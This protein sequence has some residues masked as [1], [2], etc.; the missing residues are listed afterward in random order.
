[1]AKKIIEALTTLSRSE[2]EIFARVPNDVFLFSNF[3][4][5][6]HPVRGKVKFDL[7]PYQKSVL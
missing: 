6:I 2:L 1:M 4:Y 7:Y 3:I 5:V